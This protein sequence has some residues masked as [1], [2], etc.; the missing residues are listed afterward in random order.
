MESSREQNPQS[1]E[2]NKMQFLG[3]HMEIST[4]SLEL[5]CR[6]L[7]FEQGKIRSLRS[8]ILADHRGAD[9]SVWKQ[10]TVCP[11]HVHVPFWHKH[12]DG[13][14]VSIKC[15]L[16]VLVANHCSCV[17]STVKRSLVSMSRAWGYIHP[18]TVALAHRQPKP[19]LMPEKQGTK[20]MIPAPE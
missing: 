6:N 2:K 7:S 8:D 18:A 17:S 19:I 15:A 11:I 9:L 3:Q 16:E 10:F 13:I 5:F 1:I 14:L 4:Q 12:T 20:N